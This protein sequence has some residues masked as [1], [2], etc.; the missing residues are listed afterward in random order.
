MNSKERKQYQEAFASL[1]ATDREALAGLIVEYLNPNYIA[2]DVVGMLLNVRSLKPGTQLV[3]KVRKGIT[4]R[5]LVPGAV[6]LASEVVVEDRANYHLSG[7]DVK[8]HANEWEL[9]SGELGTV[10]DIEAEMRAKIR[11][12]YI[13]QVFNALATL[14]DAVNT[15]NNFVNVGGALTATALEN[16]IDEINYRVGSA[17]V[18]IGTR[19]ALTPITKFANYVPYAGDNSAWGVP[20]PSAIEEIRKTGFVG[21]YYGTKIIGLDQIWDNEVDYTAKLP[22]DKILVLG[23]N[24]GEFITYGDIKEKQWTDMEPTPPVWKLELYQQYGL[25]VDRQ[26]GVYVIGGLS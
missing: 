14:W 8:V 21:V 18:V 24:V 25:I 10:A 17:K 23:E 16:A 3:K 26:V 15:P 12:Y 22:E 20:V 19:K 11:D 9:Q 2:T 5:T 7:V 13:T 4:V 6:H 1:A